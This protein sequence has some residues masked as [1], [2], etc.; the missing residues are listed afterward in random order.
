MEKLDYNPAWYSIVDIENPFIVDRISENDLNLYCRAYTEND[1]KWLTW[2]RYAGGPLIDQDKIH[3]RIIEKRVNGIDIGTRK[4]LSEFKT[5]NRK[6][7]EKAIKDW[8]KELD[9]NREFC[10]LDGKM[11]RSFLIAYL[12]LPLLQEYLDKEIYKKV[13]VNVYFRQV[14]T[15]IYD[16]CPTIHA[17]LIYFNDISNYRELYKALTGDDNEKL[18]KEMRDNRPDIYY[19]RVD[20]FDRDN[21]RILGFV[22]DVTLK[23]HYEEFDS[24]KISI[25]RGVDR[26]EVDELVW[27]YNHPLNEKSRW[28]YFRKPFYSIKKIEEK[29]DKYILYFDH[30]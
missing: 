2:N 23:K 20:K 12:T 7:C 4:N 10:L 1:P 8:K 26:K 11:N 30:K 24:F 18:A 25:D 9:E 27:L 19:Q 22:Y 13:D 28:T 17:R 21:P 14:N 15:I 16:G 29:D 5:I 3:G 6:K